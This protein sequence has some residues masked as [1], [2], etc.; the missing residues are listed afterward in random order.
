MVIAT[1]DNVIP[2]T[3]PPYMW[4]ESLPLW[5]LLLVR[6]H[7]WHSTSPLLIGL[8]LPHIQHI[9]TMVMPEGRGIS[10][11]RGRFATENGEVGCLLSA[12]ASRV[13]EASHGTCCV[14]CSGASSPSILSS[15]HGNGAPSGCADA[16]DA[17]P[18]ARP[19]SGRRPAR[20]AAVSAA[21][22]RWSGRCAPHLSRGL[23]LAAGVAA[24]A[25]AFAV[26]RG[27]CLAIRL[28]P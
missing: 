3:C 7:H 24:H 27:A 5:R 16:R 11:D 15:H 17:S 19:V 26:P 6:R 20:P 12:G 22:A 1:R 23:A 18:A 28:P 4:V 8:V 25:V 14:S 13:Q 9:S 10:S 2:A 21:A